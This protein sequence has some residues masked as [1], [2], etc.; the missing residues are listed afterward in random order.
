[1]RE[2]VRGLI[3]CILS[4]SLVVFLLDR[5]DEGAIIISD[6]LRVKPFYSLLFTMLLIVISVWGLLIAVGF[7]RLKTLISWLLGKYWND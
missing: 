2:K 7:A 3:I 6:R 4:G 1:M 5:F